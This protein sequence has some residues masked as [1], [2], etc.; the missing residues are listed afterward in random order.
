VNGTQ[1]AFDPASARWSANVPLSSGF[2]RFLLQ[3]LDGN[4]VQFF[5]TNQDVVGDFPSV[6][7]GGLL[8]PSTA[9]PSST[10][11][12]HGTNSLIVPAGAEPIRTT[13]SRTAPDSSYIITDYFRTHFTFN[14]DLSEPACASVMSWT[15]AWPFT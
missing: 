15:T 10:G 9:C 6:A 8:G 5:D 2:N 1:A 11:V 3:A 14:G 12:F 4:G 13:L 7:I